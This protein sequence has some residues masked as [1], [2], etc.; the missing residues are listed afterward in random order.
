M[1]LCK[2]GR[3]QRKE[4]ELKPKWEGVEASRD[5]GYSLT[6]LEKSGL[7][8]CHGNG[9]AA[10]GRDFLHR[11]PDEERSAFLFLAEPVLYG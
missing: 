6:G 10:G 7:M 1:F 3:G 9:L 5:L 2:C 8:R 11:D 4:S